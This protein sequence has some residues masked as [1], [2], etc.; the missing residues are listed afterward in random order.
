MNM[1]RGIVVGD[2]AVGKTSLLMR[3]IDK[4]F[5]ED[6]VPT[7]F[8]NHDVPMKPVD[9][10]SMMSLWDTAG[11]EQYDR[12]RC[13]CYPNTDIFVICYDVTNPGSYDN[14]KIKWIP[15]ITHYCPGIPYILVA[16]KIDQRIG[17]DEE[18]NCERSGDRLA[19][20]IGALCYMEC[21]AATDTGVSELF[22]LVF[23]TVIS[24][25]ETPSDIEE[26]SPVAKK[27]KK[28]CSIL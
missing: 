17:E 9:K 15:E 22:D 13:L 11:Q 8:E 7:V 19:K 3:F 26:K 18:E 21:S 14:I 5:P 1:Y 2:G 27:K 20:E 28:R 4:K 16:T 23:R 25:R 24:T 12:L 6:Y 10:N